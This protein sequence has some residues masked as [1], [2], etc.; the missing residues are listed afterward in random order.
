MCIRDR[1]YT[2]DQADIL[3]PLGPSSIGRF[4]DGYVQNDS[5]TGQYMAKVNA[6]G[7]ALSRGISLT[8]DDKLRGWVI[9]RL[10]CDYAF[11]LT[12]VSAQFGAPADEIT[13]RSGDETSLS[14]L[15]R[16]TGWQTPDPDLPPFARRVQMLLRGARRT[17]GPGMWQIEWIDDGQIC[18]LVTA[19][20]S[21]AP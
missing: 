20:K 18:Y 17:F 8:S 3:L 1:G 13:L 19:A 4:A 9:E 16:L 2:D 12:D 5:A 11:S 21:T 10:M 14:T 6:G 7:L 15:P